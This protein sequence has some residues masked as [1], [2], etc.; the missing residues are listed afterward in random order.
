MATVTCWQV[1]RVVLLDLVLTCVV[2]C[3]LVPHHLARISLC[4][5]ATW[6]NINQFDLDSTHLARERAKADAYYY[7]I[8]KDA[9]ANK[10][11]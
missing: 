2:N 6:F 3:R 9:E 10:V 1:C 7:K 11:S 4:G 8:Q 5:C